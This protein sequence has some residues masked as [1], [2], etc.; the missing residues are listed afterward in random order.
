MSYKGSY[1]M[2]IPSQGPEQ[3]S[4]DLAKDKGD[5]EK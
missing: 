5:L 4:P 2:K 1:M 3:S